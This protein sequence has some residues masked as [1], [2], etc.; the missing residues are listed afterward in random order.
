MR[1]ILSRSNSVNNKTLPPSP[2]RPKP[3]QLSE[4]ERKRSVHTSKPPQTRWNQGTILTRANSVASSRP[5]FDAAFW[6]A[7]NQETRPRGVSLVDRQFVTDCPSDAPLRDQKPRESGPA[8]PRRGSSLRERYPGDMSHRPLD[9]LTRDHKSK[10]M[11]DNPPLPRRGGSLRERYP[12]DMSHRP[13]DMLKRDHR[14]ADRAPHLPNHHR[15]QPSDVIDSLDHTGPVPDATY[16][17]DG[18]FDPTMKARNVKPKYSPVEAVKDSNMEAL[19]ATPVDY[20]KDA[21]DKHVPLQGTAVVPPGEQDLAG[22]TMRYKEDRIVSLTCHT[23]ASIHNLHELQPYL[24]DNWKVKSE[25][26]LAV[27]REDR[28]RKGKRVLRKPVFGSSS[29]IAIEMQP[30]CSTGRK[31]DSDTYVRHQSVSNFDQP[32]PPPP[33]DS[34]DDFISYPIHGNIH[35]RNTTGRSLAESIRRRFGSLRR[36]KAPAERVC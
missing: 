24:Q 36:R 12:G 25:A 14:V 16:H 18:P 20:L 35:R 2:P 21:L 1:R 34:P 6:A 7:R 32:P 8:L 17:H 15:Q 9:M 10:E 11:G 31:T 23:P 29:A 28:D 33:K 19:K 3:R 13:L 27:E 30:P 26:S 4:L 22:R 5:S